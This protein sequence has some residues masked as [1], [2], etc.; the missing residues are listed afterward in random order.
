MR[1]C[2]SVFCFAQLQPGC[3]AAVFVASSLHGGS[4]RQQTLELQLVSACTVQR[5]VGFECAWV[6]AM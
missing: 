4:I 6:H 1:T 5:P 2:V 3:A